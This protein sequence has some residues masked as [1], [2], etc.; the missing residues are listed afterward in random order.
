MEVLRVHPAYEMCETME[1]FITLM[2]WFEGNEMQLELE[3]EMQL[4][5]D[6]L[7]KGP[8]GYYKRWEGGNEEHFTEFSFFNSNKFSTTNRVDT[9]YEG[10]LNYRWG[11]WE[12]KGEEIHC[13]VTNQQHHGSG[14]GLYK[15]C[16]VKDG[17]ICKIVDNT[18]HCTKSYMDICAKT[19]YAI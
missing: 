16:D 1:T 13:H 8:H 10:E 2:E 7:T 6:K 15:S 19:F 18:L 9:D 5:M 3:A 11:T 4:F 12:K 17:F 14:D